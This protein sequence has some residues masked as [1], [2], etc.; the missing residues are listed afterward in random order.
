MADLKLVGKE[1]EPESLIEKI[2]L[3]LIEVYSSANLYDENNWKK[4]GD[5]GIKFTCPAKFGLFYSQ[6]SWGLNPFWGFAGF[7]D[8][9]SGKPVWMMSFHG[10]FFKGFPEKTFLLTNKARIKGIRNFLNEALSDPIEYFPLRGKSGKR[11]GALVYH[12][13]TVNNSNLADFSGKELITHG[14]EGRYS[15]DYIGGIIR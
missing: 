11:S 1:N 9:K 4:L 5:G 6:Y 14:G 12:N 3:N 10:L 2:R 8:A 7:A 13:H 15:C